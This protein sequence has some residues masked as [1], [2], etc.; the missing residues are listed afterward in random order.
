MAD[1]LAKENDDLKLKTFFCTTLLL[2][3]LLVKADTISLVQATPG[4]DNL[5]PPTGP[6]ANFGGLLDFPLSQF[7]TGGGCISY[8]ASIYAAQG[9][10]ISSPNG[11]QVCSL[12]EQ[13]PS[14]NELFDEGMGGT[15]NTTI[16]LTTGVS[17]IGVGLSD[18]DDPINVTIEVLGAGGSDLDTINV[19]NQ[20]EQAENLLVNAGQTYFVLQD[21]TPGDIFGLEIKQTD[22]SMYN[23]GLAIADIQITPEPSSIAYM[24]AGIIAIIGCSRLRKKA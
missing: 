13:G 6:S 20:V 14:P 2:M 21:S 3:P 10:N 24:V 22:S 16:S 7:N 5:S 23:S 12:D 15:A 19:T 1:T 17:E 8:N 9:V 11:L 18:F 4:N